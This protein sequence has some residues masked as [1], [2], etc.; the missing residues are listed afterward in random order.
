[1]QAFSLVK[2][3]A[4]FTLFQKNQIET[5]SQK[6]NPIS[7]RLQSNTKHFDSCWYS[8]FFYDQVFCDEIKLRTYIEGILYQAGR[9]KTI[10]SIQ[11]QYK[12]YCTFLFF[13]DQRA[14]RHKR[15][16]S[17]KLSPEPAEHVFLPRTKILP[18]KNKGCIS[19]W[20]GSLFNQ[21]QVILR[22][23][24][25]SQEERYNSLVEE[26]AKQ[27]RSGFIP[28]GIKEYV[29][30]YAIKGF[31]LEALR[32]SGLDTTKS[33]NRGTPHAYNS[34]VNPGVKHNFFAG[35]A[36]S[37]KGSNAFY[38]KSKGFLDFS[39]QSFALVRAISY[40]QEK[41][42]KATTL[43]L[44]GKH[45]F[46][47]VGV[48]FQS[49]LFNVTKAKKTF[50]SKTRTIKEPTVNIFSIKEG[51]HENS[52]RRLVLDRHS[53]STQNRL[54]FWFVKRL[55]KQ[56]RRTNIFSSL[57]DKPFKRFSTSTS[58]NLLANTDL[59]RNTTYF[60]QQVWR[61][62]SKDLARYTELFLNIYSGNFWY[63]TFYPIRAISPFQSAGFLVESIAYL[64]Q[65]K[66][67]FRQI[68]DDIFRELDQYQL[69]KGARLSCA[70]RLGGRSKKAQKAKTQSAQWG[71]TSLT[72]FSSRLAFASK[73]VNTT[74]GKVG[75]KLWL[76]YNS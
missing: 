67:S 14:E 39:I 44:S 10:P 20:D 33:F 71:E 45:T 22:N 30:N 55:E 21:A 29:Y 57:V 3:V 4:S 28:N 63:H 8:G 40:I 70:G 73:G 1:V 48:Q 62:K 46:D 64:L 75:V 18:I 17:L 26:G 60:V 7:L 11:S 50:L 16:F 68:K 31:S 51:G 49:E 54:S 53:Q 41:P 34:I 6:T 15:E 58:I 12:R 74:Y 25:L 42:L 72:V 35:G 43:V 66:N 59:K 69:I 27:K 32:L 61:A 23:E 52:F 5:M 2:L 76:C 24:R 19:A 56:L 9:S 13:F 36:G 65:R 37:I 38:I 47:R